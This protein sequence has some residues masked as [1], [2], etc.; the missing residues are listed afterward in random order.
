MMVCLALTH[1]GWKRSMLMEQSHMQVLL[2]LIHAKKPP[3][4]FLTL[5]M[6]SLITRFSVPC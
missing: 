1:S 6:K 3:R 2:G 5:N 4:A